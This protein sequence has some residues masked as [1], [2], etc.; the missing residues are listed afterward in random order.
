[1]RH[2]IRRFRFKTGDEHFLFFYCFLSLTYCYRQ[3]N[4][5]AFSCPRSFTLFVLS[6]IT[7]RHSLALSIDSQAAAI[8]EPRLDGDAVTTG[9]G[10]WRNATSSFSNTATGLPTSPTTIDHSSIY[11]TETLPGY[12]GVNATTVP[13]PLIDSQS[14]ATI[15]SAISSSA[16]LSAA[17]ISSKRN[18]CKPSTSIAS[19]PSQLAGQPS[20]AGTPNQAVN[21]VAGSINFASSVASI[22]ASSG[23]TGNENADSGSPAAGGG[24]PVVCNQPATVTV[25][26]QYT[27]TVTVTAETANSSPVNNAIAAPVAVNDYAAPGATGAANSPSINNVVAANSPSIN[28]VVAANSPSIKDVVAANSLSINNVVAAPASITNN[29]EAALAA[30]TSGMA[31]APPVITGSATASKSYKTTCK[32]RTKRR[33]SNAPT[34]ATSTLNENIE[35][36]AAASASISTGPGGLSNKDTPVNFVEK[37]ATLASIPATPAQEASAQSSSTGWQSSG[38][39]ASSFATP[40]PLSSNFPMSASIQTLSSLRNAT[41]SS[42]VAWQT[43]VGVTSSQNASSTLSSTSDWKSS[44]MTG[45]LQSTTIPSSSSLAIPAST[46]GYS[47]QESTTWTTSASWQTSSSQATDIPASGTPAMPTSASTSST[48]TVMPNYS[49][50]TS[51]ATGTQATMGSWN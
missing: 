10:I 23:Q 44:L 21:V 14:S 24:A 16:A 40:S 47:P 38:G 39:I 18:K 33:T 4:M 9:A 20:T 46:Q 15:S 26:T 30:V 51:V 29:G 13:S 6:V 28:N 42:G 41:W 8:L 3:A 49:N 36:T 17:K 5:R 7:L 32:H 43:S 11:L 27:V 25:T 34:A 37:A 35:A 45:S 12:S 50:V 31:A 19:I 2:S 1:M 48:Y 22:A